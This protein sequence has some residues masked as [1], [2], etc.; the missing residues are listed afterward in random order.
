MANEMRRDNF[1]IV[2]NDNFAWSF[3]TF[4]DRRNGYIF[5][6]NPNRWPVGWAGNQ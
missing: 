6:V 2:R 3:D 1:G 4:F 5:E